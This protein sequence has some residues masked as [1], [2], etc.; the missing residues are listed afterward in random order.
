MS[1]VLDRTVPTG[2]T[3]TP[4]GRP[5]RGLRHAGALAVRNLVKTVRTPE[6]LIDVTIQPIIF[7]LLFTY[8][9]GGALGG[10]DR[11]SYLQYLL[12]GILAQSISLAGVS[13]GQNLNSDIQ[14][15]VF[16]RFRSLPIARSAPLVGAV[17]ADVVRYLILF[18]VIMTAAT[19]MGFR[20]QTG[21]V[22][23]LAALGVSMAFALSFCW[24]SVF[25]GLIVR[26]PGAVQGLM[27]LLV[28]PLSFGSNVFVNTASMP[29]WLQHFV[30]VNPITHLVGVVRGLMLGGPV[31]SD[32]AWTGGWIAV[33]LAV[34]VPLALRA[35][36][37]RA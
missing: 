6:A 24:I 32:L 11:S 29:G 27:F 17:L 3:T 33:F 26:T 4:P 22:P 8:I 30:Q 10:G 34:F 9:F 7:L 25:V 21:F 37:R 15:G 28:M 31:A 1:T 19:V 14:K 18:A 16:D 13:L 36:N 2:T 23:T 35:Y 20:V 5:F 12:P